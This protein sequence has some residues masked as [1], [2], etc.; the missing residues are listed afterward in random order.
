MQL[1]GYGKYAVGLHALQQR[2]E[3]ADPTRAHVSSILVD[4]LELSSLS[5]FCLGML[6][7]TARD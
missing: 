7:N 4:S 2:L 5:Q 1:I 6:H 3:A